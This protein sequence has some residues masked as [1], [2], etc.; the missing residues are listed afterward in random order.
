ML[1]SAYEPDPTTRF[2]ETPMLIMASILAWL[3]V[4][5]GVAVFFG[6]VAQMEHEP[7][8]QTQESAHT[9]RSQ[10]QARNASGSRIRPRASL[11]GISR[12]H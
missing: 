7:S 8:P 12:S 5:L 11:F 2:L 1:R 10:A 6:L 4:G 9:S 3:V